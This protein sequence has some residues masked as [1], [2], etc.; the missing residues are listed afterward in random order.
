MKSATRYPHVAN[1]KYKQQKTK[2][3]CVSLCYLLLWWLPSRVANNYHVSLVIIT[4]LFKLGAR[5]CM[6]A[7]P[8]SAPPVWS[9]QD[10]CVSQGSDGDHSLHLRLH[11]SFLWRLG[12]CLPC[13]RV[14]QACKCKVCANQQAL[15]LIFMII[16][17]RGPDSNVQPAGYLAIGTCI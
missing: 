3:T 9:L 4:C 1:T 13:D 5:P 15:V 7:A 16:E 17:S 10:G 14:W 12:Y 8:P 11:T 2:Q 6:L